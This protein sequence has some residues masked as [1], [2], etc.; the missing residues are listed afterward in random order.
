[1]V[2]LLFNPENDLALAQG[3]HHYCPPK[4]IVA[5]SDD[6]DILP[7]W[8]AEKND[9]VLTRKPTGSHWLD[10]VREELSLCK[11][12][13]SVDEYWKISSP[14][15]ELNPWG[16]NSTLF[17]EWTTKG[18]SLQR[19]DCAKIRE[20]SS[21]EQVIPTLQN[22]KDGQL[23]P[24]D[25][26]FPQKLE[27][28]N[29]LRLFVES[30]RRAILKSPWSSSGK[31]LCW[32]SGEWTYAIERWADKLLRNQGF[33]MGEKAYDKVL[34]FAMEFYAE[35]DSVSF[36]GYSLFKTENGRYKCNL[37]DSDDSLENRLTNYV[38]RT[39]L[40]EVQEK[41]TDY[42]A[43]SIAPYYQ[44]Y[45]GVDMMICSS[46]ANFFVHPCV[47]INLRMN[48]GVV[49]HI[50]NER[51][52]SDSSA[53]EYYVKSFASQ[54]ELR[55]YCRACEECYPLRMEGNRI[56]EGFLPLTNYEKAMT[57]VAFLFVRKNFIV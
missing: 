36:A 55:N 47:E 13:V 12:V 4:N 5:F 37:L 34:D 10:N 6:L 41:L 26:V 44:G 54:E 16:W 31:G 11:S 28:K 33:V 14:E 29:D 32:T 18:K 1:M 48:M 30:N 19:V 45:F 17:Q 27:S 52:L 3:N 25:F 51:Y 21:R 56:V 50:L 22:L 40:R 24:V 8:Y 2:F 23:L 57:T 42:F 7:L 20:L 15:D 39:N 38:P 49:S 46:E 43:S 53:G 9:V 35:K